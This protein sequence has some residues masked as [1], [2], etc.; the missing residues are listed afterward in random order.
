MTHQHIKQRAYLGAAFRSD[1]R[2][3]EALAART[4]ASTTAAASGFVPRPDLNLSFHGGRTSPSLA[5][6]NFYLG[7]AVAWAD[8]DVTNIDQALGRAMT[9]RHLNNVLQQYFPD[10]RVSCTPLGSRILAGQPPRVFTKADVEGTV[11]QL[12][13]DG[14]LLGVGQ[15]VDLSQTVFNFLLPRGTILFS[16]EAAS[17]A[18]VGK[19]R[20]AHDDAAYRAGAKKASPPNG[21]LREEEDSLHGLGGY[22]GSVRVS[23]PGQPSTFAYYAVGVFSEQLTNHR[24]NGI[25]AFD[26]SWKDVVATFYHELCETRTNPDVEEVSRTGNDSLLGWYSDPAGEI[27]DI[28]MELA[29][30]Q[31]DLVMKEVPLA[32][33]HANV[34]IQLQWSNAVGAPEG[35]I[36][37]PHKPLALI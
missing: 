5:Y 18:R 2:A 33:G 11:A 19:H 22:H 32:D 8:S 10:D 29:G 34:P 25:P 3:A 13:G 15:R 1:S 6:F 27:G 7:G 31:L 9:D 26:A 23:Q 17:S 24:G 28:P 4:G 37:S 12:F 36:D 20:A 30:A 16:D 21:E 14:T 35:P